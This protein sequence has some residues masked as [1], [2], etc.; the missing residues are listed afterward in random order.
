MFANAVNLTH[1]STHFQ[2]RWWSVN[3]CHLLANSGTNRYWKVNTETE[4]E[5]NCSSLCITYTVCKQVPFLLFTWRM[6]AELVILHY[7]VLYASTIYLE[8]DLKLLFWKNGISQYFWR[9]DICFLFKIQRNF[10]FL[11]WNF[12]HFNSSWNSWTCS[13]LFDCLHA[14]INILYEKRWRYYHTSSWMAI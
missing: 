11:K 6:N 10:L 8:S 4:T 1:L 12:L 9:W 7:V 3:R 2:A 14:F 13:A 5:M